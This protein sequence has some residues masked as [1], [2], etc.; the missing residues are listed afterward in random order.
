[1]SAEVMI[2]HIWPGMT[3]LQLKSLLSN[4]DVKGVVMQ[5]F[6]AGNFPLIPEMLDVLREAIKAGLVSLA[7]ISSEFISLMIIYPSARR[8]RITMR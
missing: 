6:G 3:A 5:T 8:Q 4:P 7:L 1:M 2:L